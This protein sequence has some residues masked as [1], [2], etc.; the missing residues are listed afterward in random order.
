M[1]VATP[2]RASVVTPHDAVYAYHVPLDGRRATHP[3]LGTKRKQEVAM[4]TRYLRVAS[5]L[6][7]ALAVPGS[8]D[9][10]A[11]D[12]VH[13]TVT[14]ACAQGGGPGEQEGCADRPNT[15]CGSKANKYTAW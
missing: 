2:C 14:E 9:Y 6:T 11:R 1:M 15:Y 3:S 13:F 4:S 7:V 8:I 5:A 12:G 10:S